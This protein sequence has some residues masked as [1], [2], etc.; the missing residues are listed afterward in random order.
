M[1]D[2]AKPE[3]V[4]SWGLCSRKCKFQLPIILEEDCLPMENSQGG[5]AGDRN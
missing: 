3:V 5:Q 4:G 2:R 1:K